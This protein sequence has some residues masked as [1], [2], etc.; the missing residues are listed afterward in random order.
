MNT[1]DVNSTKRLVLRT[2][3]AR[4]AISY[5]LG[6]VKTNRTRIVAAVLIASLPGWTC[7]TPPAEAA[8]ECTGVAAEQ[9]WHLKGCT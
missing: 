2:P 4:P 1:S 8:P 5:A 9:C 7:D 3:E 6:A